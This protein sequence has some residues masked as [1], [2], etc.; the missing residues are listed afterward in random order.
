MLRPNF[1]LRVFAAASPHQEKNGI[2]PLE[3]PF[4]PI[5]VNC[6]IIFRTWA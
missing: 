2:L 3:N 1:V 5:L 6:F 4:S